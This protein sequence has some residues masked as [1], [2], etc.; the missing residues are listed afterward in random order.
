METKCSQT[1]HPIPKERIRQLTAPHL[2]LNSKQY[3][4]ILSVA[5]NVSRQKYLFVTAA[6]S[7]HYKESQALVLNLRKTIFSK[8]PPS[9]YSFHY[10]DLGLTPLERKRVNLPIHICVYTFV[11]LFM[12]VIFLSWNAFNYYFEMD[13]KYYKEIQISRNRTELLCKEFLSRYV[14]LNI[15]HR[16]H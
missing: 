7:N 11:C 10:F 5:K 13:D 12:C 9:S 14:F 2:R 8:L 4:D 1:F 15:Y 16:A 3:E 6:S